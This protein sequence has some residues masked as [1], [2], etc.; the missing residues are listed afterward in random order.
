MTNGEPLD[1]YKLFMV[2]KEKGG[3]DAVCKNRL[4]DLVGEEYG[5]GGKVGSSVELVYSKH[6]G[7]LETC[8]KN[9]ADGK[10]R[11]GGFVD[12]RVKFCKRKIEA[13]VESLSKD[14]VEEERGDEFERRVCECPDGRKLC[15]TNRVKG[16]KPESNVA[17]EVQSEGYVDLD[18]LDNGAN[19][20][21]PENFC[22]LNTERD[23]L[24]V[25]GVGKILT[26]DA[27]D[28]E[29]D[30]PML[31]DGSKS[32]DND[33]DNNS[34]EV[35]ILDPSSVDRKS[36]GR[37]R[38]RETKSE[39]LSWITSIAKNPCDP[40]VGSMPEKSKWKSYSSREM[41]KQALLFRES[42]F[43]KKDFQTT[44]E[45]LSWQGQKMHPS[46][47]EDRV[48][49]VY[50]LRQRLKC[51]KRLLSGNSKSDGVSSSIGTHGGSEKTPSP[52]VENRP[53]KQLLDSCTARSSR[54]KCARVRVPVGP[55]HQ[56]EVPKWTDMTYESDSKWLG[57]QIWPLEEVNSKLLVAERDPIG[58]GRQDSC[59]CQVQGSVE[60]VRFHI[61]KQK[62][63]VK[64]EL[65]DAFFRWDFHKAGE[66]VRG[67]WTEQEE[68]KFKDVVKSNPASLDK[69]FW[70]HLFKTFPTKSRE[71]LV[72]YYF[73]VFL[74]QRRA[75]QNRYT[76]DNIDSDDDE[77]EFTPLRKIF[78]HQS[79][80]SRSFTLLSPK[81]AT[82]KTAK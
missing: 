22:S 16:V 11:E 12:D 32:C 33:D 57:T 20:P 55:K 60:C 5:L 27:S 39:M 9:V 77:S 7:A 50:S 58:K 41:W 37:K 71:D 36:F 69:C 21:I 23:I 10:F 44:T 43:L 51:D 13:P 70:D 54:D 35:L 63:K 64:L 62:S 2:V 28:A 59:G 73:N 68:K 29:S 3:Y 26:V 65:G 48:G 17:N 45:K 49:G 52:R 46:M 34:G 82:D 42:V 30:M 78:G 53:E 15:G 1:L 72:S 76:P 80:K 14:Y 31:S 56:A 66:E 74:L 81:K 61:V 38:K 40:A 25:P 75:Y 19:E 47:Y 67:S 8:F 4:W 24:N 6:L 18:M 79:Q